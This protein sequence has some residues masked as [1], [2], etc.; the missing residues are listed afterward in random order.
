MTATGIHLL[1]LSVGLLGPA[2]H[3]YARVRQ[4]GSRLVNG[5]TLGVLVTH[6]SGANALI[7]AVLATPFDGRFAVYGN[8]GWAEVRDKAHP[9]GARGMDTDGDEEELASAVDLV[10]GRQSGARQPGSVRGCGMGRAVPGAA[11]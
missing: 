3:V 11:G 9:G 8:K 4:L 6:K 5:D 10:P 1:D 2:Q 7:S